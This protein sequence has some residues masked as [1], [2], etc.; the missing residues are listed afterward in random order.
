MARRSLFSFLRDQYKTIPPVIIADLKGKTIIVIG[1][2][3]GI[4]FEA[5]QHLAR[6]DV[7][8]LILACR[9]QERGEAAMERELVIVLGR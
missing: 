4:G 2:N 8:R 1:A 6:M 7:G 3:T 5:A 9:S